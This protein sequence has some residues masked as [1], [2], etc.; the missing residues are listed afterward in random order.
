M[1]ALRVTD[2][3]ETWS[4]SGVKGSVIAA[5]GTQAEMSINVLL[6]GLSAV[7]IIIVKYTYNKVN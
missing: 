7:S 5:Q 6:Y 3:D 1:S 2:V 4:S